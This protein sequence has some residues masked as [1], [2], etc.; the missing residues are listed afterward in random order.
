MA[1]DH[2]CMW[3]KSHDTVRVARQDTG[4]ISQCPT[5]S[6]ENRKKNRHRLY[7][8]QIHHHHRYR[9]HCQL[10]FP[11]RNLESEYNPNTALYYCAKQQHNGNI[12]MNNACVCAYLYLYQQRSSIRIGRAVC[13][14]K[15]RKIAKSSANRE[16]KLPSKKSRLTV[17]SVFWVNG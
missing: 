16:G 6:S 14:P 3:S 9:Y 13:F 2:G 15:L 11:V 17:A 7:S 5:T 10:P 1:A 8:Y 4:R 12:Y